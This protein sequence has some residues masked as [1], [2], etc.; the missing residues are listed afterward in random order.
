MICQGLELRRTAFPVGRTSDNA[1]IKLPWM[2]LSARISPSIT[3]SAAAT[4][5]VVQSSARGNHFK[6]SI[7]TQDGETTRRAPYP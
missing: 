7:E 2:E 3:P 5:Q 1:R 4:L 6:H